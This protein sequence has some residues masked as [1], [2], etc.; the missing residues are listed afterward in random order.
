VVV[1]R[2]FAVKFTGAVAKADLRNV[3]G[4]F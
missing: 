1:A 2:G 4:I 3:S